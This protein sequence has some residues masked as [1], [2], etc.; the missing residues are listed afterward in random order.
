M[1][2]EDITRAAALIAVLGTAVVYGT[3]V[4]CGWCC[5]RPWRWS[6]TAPWLR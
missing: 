2:L 1:A 3:D 4:F 6:T 5:D